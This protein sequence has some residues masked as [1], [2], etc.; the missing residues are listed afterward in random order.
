M[1]CC[2]SSFSENICRG[3]VK[4]NR[5]LETQFLWVRSRRTHTTFQIWQGGC[6]SVGFRWG[7]LP[8]ADH[9][10]LCV[11]NCSFFAT[12]GSLAGAVSLFLFYS[13]ELLDPTDGFTFFYIPLRV[14]SYSVHFLLDHLFL[15]LSMHN[16]IFINLATC[17]Y[18]IKYIRNVQPSQLYLSL[19]HCPPLETLSPPNSN[20]LCD[21]LVLIAM[22]K[23]MKRSS[24]RERGLFLGSWLEGTVQHSREGM[25][26]GVALDCGSRSMGPPVHISMDQKAEIEQAVGL[27]YKPHTPRV[28]QHC[29][30]NASLVGG[31]VSKKISLWG[32]FY[33]QTVVLSM[34][35]SHILLWL[36][37]H[38]RA[39]GH[40]KVQHIS[41][42]LSILPS[43]PD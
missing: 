43:V 29:K 18:S 23:Y 5:S 30:K 39:V 12:L 33:M 38:F 27:S 11:K 21:L 9:K 4:T 41:G 31:Q 24:L 10:G 35:T 40:C 6:A 25:K 13:S 19:F 15:W 37:C 28:L 7:T 17:K 36:V 22:T 2:S 16:I 20:F 1:S 14:S 3:E 32:T 42:I 26:V 8:A 34:P